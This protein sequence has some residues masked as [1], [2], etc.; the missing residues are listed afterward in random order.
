MDNE[1]ILQKLIETER[2]SR[3]LVEEAQARI[4]RR[5]SETKRKAEEERRRQREDAVKALEAELDATRGLIRD[6]YD[7][8]L[9]AYQSSLDSRPS[10]QTAFSACLKR[11]LSTES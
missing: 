2:S 5:M 4:D 7:S 1:D 8:L 10:D 6:E 3:E 9:E 11:I